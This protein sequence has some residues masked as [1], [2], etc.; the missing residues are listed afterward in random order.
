MLSSGLTEQ[1]PFSGTMAHLTWPRELRGMTPTQ[2]LSGGRCRPTVAAGRPA[3]GSQINSASL[4]DAILRAGSC[5]RL[6]PFQKCG[7]SINLDPIVGTSCLSSLQG[8]IFPG[9]LFRTQF[10]LRIIMRGLSSGDRSVTQFLRKVTQNG[11]YTA[12]F[13]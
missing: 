1:D 9:R 5:A 8:A 7:R 12:I 10:Q 3:W 13:I 6:R 2:S 4:R 11:R